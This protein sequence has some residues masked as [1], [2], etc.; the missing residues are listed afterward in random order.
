MRIYKG[1]PMSRPYILYGWHLSY[2]TGKVRCYLQYKGIAFVD[3]AVDLFTLTQRIKRK[4]GAVVMPVLR[5]PHDTWIQDSSEIIDRMEDLFPARSVVPDT[6]IQKFTAYLLEAWGDE[7]WIPIA[8]HTRW[9]YGENY[10]LFEREA[11]G[12]LLPGFPRWLQRRA[13]GFVAG[14]LRGML[15][16]VGVRAEQF[17]LLNDWTAQM[18]DL[19]D[20]HFARVPYLL[21]ARPTLADFS[22]VGT[23]YGHLGRDPWPKR[24]MIAPRPALKDWI[25]RMASPPP[26]D[27]GAE[28]LAG[29]AIAPTLEPIL[30]AI[31]A[32]FVPMV[33]R[34]NEQVVVLRRDWPNGKP[35]PRSLADVEIPIGDAVLRRAALPYTLWM[36]Q[37]VHDVFDALPADEKTTVA[38]WLE[39][40]GGERLLQL[41]IPRL[42]RMGLRVAPVA[43]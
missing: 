9:S 12:H 2:F 21:G 35:L 11:G 4:T 17:Q 29:D 39:G 38:L 27:Q 7:W 18:C 16:R 32:Q 40:L 28:L 25:D 31:F 22:L 5:T 43:T 23:M 6:P 30:R 15:Q 8:M 36:V 41:R 14:N 10:P 24:V 3:Q 33:E 19:L 37:R 42:Q 13:A 26:A 20:A 1:Q 34:I